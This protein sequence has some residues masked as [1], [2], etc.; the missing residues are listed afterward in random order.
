MEYIVQ[1]YVVMWDEYIDQT[2]QNL[3]TWLKEH[4]PKFKS[5]QSDVA[6]HLLA[7]ENHY[8]DLNHLLVLAI[9]Q[10]SKELLIKETILIQEHQPF[11]CLFLILNWSTRTYV[12]SSFI[13]FLLLSK[14][15]LNPQQSFHWH[16]VFWSMWFE[17]TSF[18]LLL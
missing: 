10:F 2:K 7:K 9:T 17:T 14:C 1:A 15:D 18:F 3:I 11:H 13:F 16:F 12:T 8:I 4:N 6:R 5:S